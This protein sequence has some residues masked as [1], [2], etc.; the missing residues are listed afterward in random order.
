METER[1][2]LFGV[3]AFQNGA[4]EAD[5]LAETCASWVAEPTLPLADLL[6]DRG[7]I[8]DEQRTEVE[9]VLA[10]ELAT[11]GGDP[12]AT[13]AA[14]IDGRTL[15]AMGDV[16]GAR[17]SLGFDIG[18]ARLPATGTGGVG[19]TREP[20]VRARRQSKSVH[21]EPFTRQGGHGPRMACP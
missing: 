18:T 15:A 3:L 5:R 16:A 17:S 7:L 10:H 2:L 6:V 13:L 1:N 20:G 4:L 8:T 11:H 9:N 21:P 12:R 19:R 14:T